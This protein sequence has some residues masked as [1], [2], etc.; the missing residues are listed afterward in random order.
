MY[1]SFKIL[2]I[3]E[4]MYSF[5]TTGLVIL[6]AVVYSHI[7]WFEMINEE[8]NQQSYVSNITPIPGFVS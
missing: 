4:A 2:D 8:S 5:T 3:G 7:S 1:E 6:E